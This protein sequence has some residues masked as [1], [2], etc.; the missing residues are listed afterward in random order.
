[1]VGFN[2]RFSPAAKALAA[3][4]VGRRSP[5]V[6]CYRVNA[7]YLPPE[8]WVQGPQG[9]GRNL[10]EACHMYDLFRFLAGAPV[11]SVAATAIDPGALPHSRS[12]NFS[13][14]LGY[15]DGSVATLVYT[16]LGPKGLAKERLEVFVDGEAYLLEDFVSLTRA[17]DGQVL[18]RSSEPDK[19]HAAGLAL[20]AEAIASGGESPTP[21]EQVVETTTAA[22]TIEDLIHGRVA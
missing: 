21:F 9:G 5:L 3:A 15:G 17:S 10:G 4:L 18:W 16:S 11:T 22:L 12:E 19:G 6:M 13:A 20:F 2:R 8:H 1:M 7:G 14:T